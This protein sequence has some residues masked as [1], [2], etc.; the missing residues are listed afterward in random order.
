VTEATGVATA[1]TIEMYKQ[2]DGSV[3]VGGKRDGPTYVASASAD[4]FTVTTGGVA[5]TYMATASTALTA[6]TAP[7][8]LTAAGSYVL[9]G[10]AATTG[11]R[12]VR[13]EPTDPFSSGGGVPGPASVDAGD[14]GVP[15]EGKPGLST[16]AIIGIVFGCIAAFLIAVGLFV[17][18]KRRPGGA[19][20]S[21]LS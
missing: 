20:G 4:S 12:T 10:G 21:R 13:F 5:T 18:Y 11:S 7:T 9:T 19:H 17:L 3:W 2:P 8:A 14:P 16:A 15:M 1:T 6:P